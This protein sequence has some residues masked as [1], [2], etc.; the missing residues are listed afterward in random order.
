LCG[1][2][3]FLGNRLLLSFSKKPQWFVEELEL[4][5]DAKLR[6]KTRSE[7]PEKLVGLRVLE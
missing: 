1:R 6:L 4:V 3:L 7:L 5:H 2:S